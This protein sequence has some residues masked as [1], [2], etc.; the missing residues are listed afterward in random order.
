MQQHYL[1]YTMV[2]SDT[3]IPSDRNLYFKWW[4][5]QHYVCIVGASKATQW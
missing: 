2:L 5:T 4:H 1:F 3:F